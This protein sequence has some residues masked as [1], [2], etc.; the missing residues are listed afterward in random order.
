MRS[1]L[2]DIRDAVLVGLAC[3]VAG[4]L[5]LAP[6]NVGVPLCA[7]ALSWLAYRRGF[8]TAVIVAVVASLML[9]LTSPIEATLIGVVMLIAGPWAAWR[10]RN[11][12][13]WGVFGVVCAAVFVATFGAIA[14]AQAAAGST[15]A[16]FFTDTA[17]L[18][19]AEASSTAASWGASAA[20]VQSQIG[21]MQ[22]V[23]TQIMPGIFLLTAGLSALLSVYAVGWVGR[24]EGEV[25]R[26][27]PPL[28]ELDLS[29][30]LTWVLI[31]ALGM[32][33]AARFLGQPSGVLSAIGENLTLLVRAALS[34]QGLAVFAG[35]YRRAKF[36]VVGRWAGYALLAVTEALT[37]LVIPIGLVSITGLIDLWVNI[38]KLP[39][40]GEPGPAE[41]AA[42]L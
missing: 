3:V 41:Q 37:P 25:L 6:Y 36:G 2:A 40:G 24:R 18:S 10:L 17:R 8:L 11:G 15:V 7:L 21:A 33:S 4:A 31:A 30:H 28:A 13:P 14:I 16:S 29:F 20:S 19:A 26:S 32:L 9:A 12:S 35:L 38:R 39:R 23:L 5:V 22:V 27:L 1:R 42:G 34:L